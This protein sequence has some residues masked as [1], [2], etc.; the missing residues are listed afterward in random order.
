V[1]WEESGGDCV[2]KSNIDYETL[3]NIWLK[4]LG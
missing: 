4:I 2:K 1:T 3:E